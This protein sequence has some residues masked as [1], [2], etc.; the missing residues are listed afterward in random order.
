MFNNV[1][2]APVSKQTTDVHSNYAM[3]VRGGQQ[4]YLLCSDTQR[5]ATALTIGVGQSVDLRGVLSSG[6][7]PTS[8]DSSHG[9]PDATVNIQSMNSDG[10][11]WTTVATEKHK[12]ARELRS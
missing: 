8:F 1:T 10:R 3:D 5:N 4:T 12:L 7:P 9:I 6:T 2:A 11:T